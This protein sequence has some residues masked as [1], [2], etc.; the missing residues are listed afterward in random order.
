MSTNRLIRLDG[1]KIYSKPALIREIYA[2][3][4]APDYAESNWD[5]LF[6]VLTESGT[7]HT[8]DI[9]HEKTLLERLGEESGAFTNVLDDLQDEYGWTIYRD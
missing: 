6:D 4:S 9:K 5:A 3:V 8:F 1:T 2:Q 7:P